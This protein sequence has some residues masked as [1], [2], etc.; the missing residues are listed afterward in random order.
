MNITLA[1]QD[2]DDLIIKHTSPPVMAMLRN[3]LHLLR[4]QMEAYITEKAQAEKL[5]AAR[6]QKIQELE[7]ANT[8]LVEANLQLQTE[9]AR[10]DSEDSKGISGWQS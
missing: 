1:F 8:K 2:L 7:S 5:H 10:R 4:D 3:K 6:E 9:I